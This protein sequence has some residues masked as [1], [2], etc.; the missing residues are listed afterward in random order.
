M[1][2]Q[3]TMCVISIRNIF[4]GSSVVSRGL[5]KKY[6]FCNP[7][8]HIESCNISFLGG[9]VLVGRYVICIL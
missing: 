1:N 8:L 2:G 7:S 5:G 3:D 6:T 4:N 9:V